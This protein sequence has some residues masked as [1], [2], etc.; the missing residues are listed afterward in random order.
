MSQI[1]NV[2]GST[3]IKTPKSTVWA[4]LADFSNIADWTDQVK[5][6]APLDELTQGLGAGRVCRLAPFGTTDERII[7]YVPEDKM[8]IELTNIKKL[9]LKRS[10]TTFSLRAIDEST[11]EATMSSVPE[12]KGGPLSRL[13]DKRLEKGLPK[14]VDGLLADLKVAAESKVEA[15]A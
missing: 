11:T 12:P 2:T 6:S 13:V 15:A 8:V 14:A 1:I 5:T 10:V 4:I 7:E 3:T 9:P